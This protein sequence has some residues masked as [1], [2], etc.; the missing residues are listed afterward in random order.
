V[1]VDRQ[2]REALAAGKGLYTVDSERL[3]ELKP[4]VIVTQVGRVGRQAGLAD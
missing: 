4:G 2:V 1:D 3:A